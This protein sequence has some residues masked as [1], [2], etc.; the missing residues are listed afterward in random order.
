MSRVHVLIRPKA[1]RSGQIVSPQERLENEIL[2]S[3]AFDRLR[4]M[5]GESFSSMARDKVEV[6]AGDLSERDLGIDP[7]EPGEGYGE[8]I[9]RTLT[10]LSPR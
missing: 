7:V 6:V 3:S 1:T 2:S 5:H 4:K 8:A 9:E 10:Q